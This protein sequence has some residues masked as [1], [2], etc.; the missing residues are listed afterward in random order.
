[1]KQGVSGRTRELEHPG[2]EQAKKKDS[3]QQRGSSNTSKKSSERSS[4][5]PP[6]SAK[7]ELENKRATGKGQ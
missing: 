4:N 2:P 3:G 7:E 1:M 5:V 6:R